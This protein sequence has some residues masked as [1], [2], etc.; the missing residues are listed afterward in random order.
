[1]RCD[2]GDL[3]IDATLKPNT[4]LTLVQFREVP[5]GMLRWRRGQFIAGSDC[6]LMH[7][8][9]AVQTMVDDNPAVENFT[10]SGGFLIID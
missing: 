7:I 6:S 5:P 9:L 4:V 3:Q 2:V 10:T 8:L 1:L